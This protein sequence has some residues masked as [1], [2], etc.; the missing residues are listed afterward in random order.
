MNLRTR[1]CSK[2][3]LNDTFRPIEVPYS[4][5]FIDK[6]EIGSNAVAGAGVEVDLWAGDT[7]G[8]H[9]FMIVTILSSLF[10]T[11]AEGG[12]Y[13]GAWTSIGCI[14]VSDQYYAPGDNFFAS[15]L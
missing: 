7:D 14:P 3:P 12:Q 11:S 8:S 2:R 6:R 15:M 4:A 9:I 13:I 10:L 1:Q 5:K